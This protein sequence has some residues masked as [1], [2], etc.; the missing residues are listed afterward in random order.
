MTTTTLIDADYATLQFYEDTG[1]V[2]HK[3]F[4]KITSPQLK[5]VLDCG[6]D[7]LKQHQ[8]IK[9]LSDNRDIDP[10]DEEVTAWINDDWLPRAVQA[11]WKYWALVVPHD[12]KARMNMTEF[13]NSFYHHGIRVMVFSQLDE[14]MEWLKRF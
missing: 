1:I 8:A 5:E 3:L 4:N 14:A 11:G 10:H 2:H 6:V 13:V 7:L 9:W 12:I